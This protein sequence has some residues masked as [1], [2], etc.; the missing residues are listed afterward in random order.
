MLNNDFNKKNLN[1]K[2]NPTISNYIY[3]VSPKKN[4]FKN[5]KEINTIQEYPLTYRTINNYNDEENNN[6]FFYKKVKMVY[7]SSKYNTKTFEINDF[8]KKNTVFDNDG[9]NIFKI[10]YN[11]QIIGQDDIR[12][13]LNSNKLHHFSGSNSNE[14]NT[15]Q[16]TDYNSIKI[17]NYMINEIDKD[18]LENKG[19]LYADE[20][21]SF[22]NI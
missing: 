22:N 15:N 20:N 19:N 16:D 12:N 17:N 6:K 1:I 13:S 7:K 18:I 4:K 21:F 2:Y 8:K 9:N 14:N 11:T 10:L 5:R 3:K